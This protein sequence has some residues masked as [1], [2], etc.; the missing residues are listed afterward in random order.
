[1]PLYE[2]GLASL[3]KRNLACGRLSFTTDAARATHFAPL[4]FIAVGTP[5]QADGSADLRHVFAVVDSIL[6]HADH[7]KV[8]VNKSTAPVGT[9][10]RIKARISQA[11]ANAEHYRV[12]SNPEF[13]KE[14]SAVDD[15]MRPERIIIGGAGPAELERCAS[16]TCRS[17]ATGKTHGHGCAQRR[18]DQVR[19]QLHAGDEDLLHQ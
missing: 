11:V 15:C 18:A 16:C 9:V 12:I 10:D 14:G 2:P 5:P 19:R 7:P 13:L 6:E 17:A 8:I 3:L 1:L 4:L